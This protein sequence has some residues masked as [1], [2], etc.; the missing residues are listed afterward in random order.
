MSNIYNK[1]NAINTAMARG[2]RTILYCKLMR[3]RF[4]D[5]NA[6]EQHFIVILISLCLRISS[7]I[8]ESENNTL[9]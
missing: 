5:L 8:I 9:L 1:I 2:S 3:R 6:L 4:P 7:N